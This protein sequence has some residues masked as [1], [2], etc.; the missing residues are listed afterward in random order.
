MTTIVKWAPLREIDLMEQ[1]MRRIFDRF[2]LMPAVLPAADLYETT[3]EFVVELEVPGFE[4]KELEVEVTDHTLLVKGE[5]KA[6]D[7]VE[8]KEFR[9]R[10]RLEET[11]ER[12][13]FLP[14]DADTEHVKAKY[15]KGV[16]EIH[17]PKLAAPAAQKIAITKE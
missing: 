10:E 7:E 6:T 11:F 1:G 9:L 5:R 3:N 2:G 15:G 14:I 4:E 12:R 17:T 8:E 13:F 16:L